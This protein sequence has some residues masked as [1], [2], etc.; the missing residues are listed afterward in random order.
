MSTSDE[1]MDVFE[2]LNLV[3]DEVLELDHRI[4]QTLDKLIGRVSKIHEKQTK[5][6]MEINALYA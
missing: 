1:P 5:L 4:T 6:H 3:F 2:R